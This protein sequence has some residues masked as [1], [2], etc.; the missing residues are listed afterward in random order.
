MKPIMFKIIFSV[1]LLIYFPIY[2]DPQENG[3]FS[4]NPVNY[5]EGTFHLGLKLGAGKTEQLGDDKFDTI[6]W[7]PVF[8]EA[9][10]SLKKIEKLKL[11]FQAGGFLVYDPAPLKP[12]IQIGL[13]YNFS[14]TFYGSVLGG[15]LFLVDAS[16][17]PF[18]E[19]PDWVGGLFFGMDEKHFFIDMGIQSI[20]TKRSLG[21]GIFISIGSRL[22]IW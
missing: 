3:K 22:K 6:L 14:N 19:A 11:L 16:V 21:I 17:K 9:Q 20:Y 10:A 18:Q 15:P 12:S 4:S 1:L 7:L 5:S 13:K 8:L 2:G